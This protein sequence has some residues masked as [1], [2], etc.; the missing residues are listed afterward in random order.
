M[1]TVLV[2]GIGLGAPEQLTL[3]AIDAINRADVFFVTEKGSD[4]DELGQLRRGLCD[5]LATTR[6]YRFA[7]ITDPPRAR[8]AADYEGAVAEWTASRAQAWG[9][10]LRHELD[11][12]QC[13]A[14][15]AWGDPAFYDS[16]L[17]VLDEVTSAAALPLRVEV[18]PGIS[19]LQALAA[20]HGISLTRVGRPV[21]L[22]TGRRLREEGIPAGAD[23]VVVMLDGETAFAGVPA[24]GWDIF[25]GAYLGMPDQVL[26]AG[27]LGDVADRIT[28]T[29]LEARAR[30]GWIMDT[31]LLR[32][33]ATGGPATASP[34]RAGAPETA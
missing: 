17:R 21:H 22:T 23:D 28:R 30:H 34:V 4:A 26:I 31:Y 9:D 20:A 13:G 6:P 12:D 14:F 33:R 29:R 2:I 18:I 24:A 7:T 19:S 25:W 11:D 8:T 1:R 15:L 3:Q 5:R 16:T 10:R 27:A 32:R